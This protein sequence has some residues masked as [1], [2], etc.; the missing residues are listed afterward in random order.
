MAKRSN[1]DDKLDA[2]SQVRRSGVLTPEGTVVLRTGLNDSHAVIVE[3][4]AVASRELRAKDLIP[5]LGGAFDRFFDDSKQDRSCITLSALAESLQSLAAVEERR[6]L[7]GL[8]L[9]RVQMPG[10]TDVAV[11]V[12][13]AC[14]LGLADMGYRDAL[15]EMA[16]FLS[17]P[18][19]RG[20]AAAA[21]ALGVIGSPA[22]VPLL[23]FKITAGDRDA[24]VMSECFKSLLALDPSHGVP[25][26]GTKLNAADEPIA[27]AAALALGES[28]RPQALELLSG[29]VR[30]NLSPQ[31]R[32]VL[33]LSIGLLRQ[34]AAVE[35]LLAVLAGPDPRAAADAIGGLAIYHRDENIRARVTAVV[36]AANDPGLTKVFQTGFK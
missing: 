24:D 3:R 33:L 30:R 27:E 22:G 32:R 7:R 4:A 2:I 15:W 20:R 19:P 8:K 34:E 9:R 14:A 21:M 28:R 11:G 16:A 10:P 29:A 18:E 23:H 17:D 35:F 25:L 31:L 1:L 26:V 13:C 12:R 6:Y 5:E 36:D